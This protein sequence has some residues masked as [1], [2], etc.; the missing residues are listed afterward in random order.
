MRVQWCGGD[1]RPT[2]VCVLLALGATSALRGQ[3]LPEH[4]RSGLW[5]RA[6]FDLGSLRLDSLHSGSLAGIRFAAGWALSEHVSAGLRTG[7]YR[8]GGEAPTSWL[9][10]TEVAWYPSAST[11]LALRGG[12][13]VLDFH[14]FSEVVIS[15]SPPSVRHQTFRGLLAHVSGTASRPIGEHVLVEFGLE[16]GYSL[17]GTWRDTMTPQVNGRPWSVA[18]ILTF[19]LD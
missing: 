8:S 16:F 5:V 18:L 2:L 15:D 13:S 6:G 7:L 1:V 19:G 11:G 14:A 9:A 3:D 12:A 4:P 10:G 17:T